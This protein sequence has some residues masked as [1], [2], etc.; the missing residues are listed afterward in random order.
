M[1]GEKN[2]RNNFSRNTGIVR[3][4]M[5]GK[6]RKRMKKTIFYSQEYRDQKIWGKK[7]LETIF[8]EK[9][10]MVRSKNVGKK[11]TQICAKELFFNIHTNIVTKKVGGKTR[12]TIFPET[13]EW[14]AQKRFEKTSQK[15]A[16]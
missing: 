3:K 8:P 14:C 4:K 16:K 15:C 11:P 5:L 12:E 10:G 2:A 13:H 6:N 9:T 7:T 1:G